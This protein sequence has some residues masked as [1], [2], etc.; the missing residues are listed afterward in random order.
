[1]NILYIDTPSI[2]NSIRIALMEQMTNHKI[3]IVDNEEKAISDFMKEPAEI[4]IYDPSVPSSSDI[5]EKILCINPKQ[6]CIS[7]S[8][9]IDCAEREG[10]DVCLANY[11]KKAVKKEQGLHSLLYLIDNFDEI[12]CEFALD[13]MDSSAI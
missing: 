3:N 9:S 1:M 13:K 12:S 7:L 5:V 10:C 2:Q 6:Q 4:L 11:N 8:D